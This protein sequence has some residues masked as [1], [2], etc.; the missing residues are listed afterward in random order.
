MG[1]SA[2]KKFAEISNARSVVEMFGS[3]WV[4][5]EGIEWGEEEDDKSRWVVPVEF[6]NSGMC[7]RVTQPDIP[8]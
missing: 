1:G 8:G 3:D 5:N 2:L 6:M 7:Q 4:S